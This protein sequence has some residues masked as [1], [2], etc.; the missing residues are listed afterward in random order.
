V[1]LDAHFAVCQEFRRDS[2]VASFGDDKKYYEADGKG[3]ERYLVWLKD[4]LQKDPNSVVHMWQ[5]DEIVGQMEMGR[6][7]P[8]PLVGYVNLFYVKPSMRGQGLGALQDQH[9]V[10]YFQGLGLKSAKLSVSPTNLRAVGFYKKLGWQDLGPR[11]QHPE[12][13]LM[14]KSF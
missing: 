8:E 11:P 14:E 13:H 5:G 9:A 1:D 10:R 6:Y 3:E 7:K 4:K 12:V 2:F